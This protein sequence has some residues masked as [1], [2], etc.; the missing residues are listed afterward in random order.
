MIHHILTDQLVVV[1]LLCYSV[2]SAEN[3]QGLHYAPVMPNMVN[4]SHLSTITT[5]PLPDQSEQL[6]VNLSPSTIRITLNT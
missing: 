4:K 1:R 5:N 2:P 6:I 3:S